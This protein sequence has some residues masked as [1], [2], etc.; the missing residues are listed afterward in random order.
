MTPDDDDLPELTAQILAALTE[1][2]VLELLGYATFSTAEV[3]QRLV[4]KERRS[5]TKRPP[6]S[7]RGC[8]RPD[9]SR[10]DYAT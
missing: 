6:H 2:A 10:G 9:C 5:S 4:E 1:Q 3:E 8:D 7:S